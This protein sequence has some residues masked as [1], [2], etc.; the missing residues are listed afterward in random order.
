MNKN[1]LCAFIASAL[2]MPAYQS[3]AQDISSPSS[4]ATSAPPA[5]AA[6][7]NPQT[8]VV[9]AR[10]NRTADKTKAKNLQAVSVTGSLIP[11]AQIEG[12]SPVTTIT[13]NDI[14]R[15]GFGS[16]FEALRAQPVSNGSVQDPQSTGGY[17]PGAETISLFGLSPSFT[18]TL[19]NGRPM[20]NYPLAYNGG[21]S[22]TDIANIPVSLIDHIDILTGAQS[23]IYGSSAIAGVVNIVMKDHIKGT[24]MGLRLGNYSNGGGKNERFSLSSGT[25]WGKLD[26]SG[27]IQLSESS[28]IFAYERRYIDSTTDD[29]TGNGGVP[30]RTYLRLLQGPNGS[31]YIDPGVASCAPLANEFFGSTRYS[32][33]PGIG[34]YCGSTENVGL[35][36]LGNKSKDANGSL[37][38]RY[39][40]SDHTQL[41][42]DLL[43]SYSD[44]TYTGGSPFW[45]NTFYNQ[46]SGQYEL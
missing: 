20:A 9:P 41:Y 30:S 8:D 46:N 16:T 29:P 22:I 28:P 19:L 40:I 5:A 15:E 31:K 21:T 1:L 4:A 24:H 36:S 3:M 33:R 45:N 42:S 17:T 27:G 38:L 26:I 39:H 7:P 23:S 14:Q 34:Y 43:Y 25:S 37:F 32:Y 13:T 2:M 10:S 35:A 6:V 12:P 44:P 18:L 11:R